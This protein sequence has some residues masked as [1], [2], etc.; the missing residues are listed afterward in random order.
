MKPGQGET[1]E[2]SNS[3]L[4]GGSFN[5]QREV[6]HEACLGRQ[7]DKWILE[8]TCQILKVYK[9]AIT[10]F[11]LYTVQV[12]STPRPCLKAIS[13][14]LLLGVGQ[15]KQDPHQGQGGVWDL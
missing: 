3:R 12:F 13:L 2:A 1:K 5:K 15:D 8:P 6:T 11:S 14:E 9:E 7:Q 10:G 4:A